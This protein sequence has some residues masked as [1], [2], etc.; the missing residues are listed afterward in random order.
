MLNPAETID[1]D[2]INQLA[3]QDDTGTVELPKPVDTH[4]DWSRYQFSA[5]G[6]AVYPDPNR[7]FHFIVEIDDDARRT[8]QTTTDVEDTLRAYAELA[9]VGDAMAAESRQSA[10]E[11][12]AA[13]RGALA[14]RRDPDRN[15]I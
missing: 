2:A 10:E 15:R 13:F 3:P 14:A 5:T 9:A 12:K 7:R 6:I 1:N 11:V 4:G 8:G